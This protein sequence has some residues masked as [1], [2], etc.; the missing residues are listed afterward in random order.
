MEAGGNG[1]GSAGA[2]SGTH[3]CA[4]LLDHAMGTRITHVPY[5]G[6][7]GEPWANK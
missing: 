6:A 1:D 4:L 7:G 3:V 2:G 5:R